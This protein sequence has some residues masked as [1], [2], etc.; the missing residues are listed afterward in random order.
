MIRRGPRPDRFVVL[1]NHTVRE[2][3]LSF[4]ARGLLA[5]L[6]SMPEDW[7]TNSNQLAGQSPKE[8]RDAIRTALVEL[9]RAGYLK[10]IRVQDDAGRWRTETVVTDSPV[11]DA[12]ENWSSYPLPETDEPAPVDPALIEI[13]KKKDLSVSSFT[14]S[15]AR[16]PICTGCH[17]TGWEPIIEVGGKITTERCHC[18][19]ELARRRP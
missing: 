9:E 1:A 8:G 4:R 17:G 13:P 11:D 14:D 5:Y 7:R 3:R 19:R 12:G 15:Y 16:E 2:A 6:L 10:R 18:H